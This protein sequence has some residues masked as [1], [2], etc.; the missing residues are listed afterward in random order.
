MNDNPLIATYKQLREWEDLD[1]DYIP[2]D[3]QEACNRILRILHEVD[4]RAYLD[5][6]VWDVGRVPFESVAESE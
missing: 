1:D 4:P 6:V 2:D 5:C 3:C